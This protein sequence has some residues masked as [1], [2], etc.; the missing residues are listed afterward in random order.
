M[1]L[2]AASSF[3]AGLAE[4]ALLVVL[5]R[6]AFS[7]GGG[8]ALTT[9]LGPIQAIKLTVRDMFLICFVLTLARAALQIYAGH[10]TARLSALLTTRIR[11]ETFADYVLASWAVQAAETESD[12]QDLLVRHVSRVTSAVSVMASGLA[13][14]F[15]LGALIA[16]AVAVD[17]LSAAL[18]IVA[19]AVLFPILKPLST[20]AKRV[21]RKQI[22]AGRRYNA[23]SLEAVDLS[24]EIRS[25]GVG[26]EVASRLEVATAAEVAPIYT[27]VL[28]SRLVQSAYQLAALL[29]LLGGLLAVD[30]FLDRPLASLGAIVVILVRALNQSG[31]L[32]STYHSMAESAP[33]AQRV[34]NERERFRD[35]R[36]PHGTH[37]LDRPVNL[38]F[39]DVSYRYVADRAALADLSFEVERGEAIGIIGPSGS[40]KSTLIQLLLRLRHPDSGRYLVGG[41]DAR[42]IDDESW[43]SQVA[44]VPQDCRVFDAT[45]RENIRFFRNDATDAEVEAAAVRAH[46]HDEIMAMPD[47]YDTVLGSR[48]GALSGG[49]RQRVAI[50]RALVRRPSLLVLDEPTSALDMRSESLVHETFTKLK[51]DVTLFVIAHRLSTLNTCDRI[52]VMGE[53]R[54]QAF[55]DREELDR[56]NEFYREAI[57]LSRIRS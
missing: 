25:F 12:V 1:L 34:L 22:D 6:L 38:S 54:L 27:S 37:R 55:G 5:A 44:F 8:S 24:L 9:G 11:R 52:M 53:G 7:I 3:L 46:V 41:V 36:P 4:A 45:I 2:L 10:I 43:F 29:I 17:P 30:T 32:Q 50:A 18:I 35:S 26:E 48:G 49:Q 19:G 39:E 51:G 20:T 31:T 23:Q 28:F 16:G 56:G 40:G 15:S 14:V 21:A 42:E 33:F 13:I 47:G 57:A